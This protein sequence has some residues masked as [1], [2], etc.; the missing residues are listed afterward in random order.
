MGDAMH[1]GGEAVGIS[2]ISVLSSE[3]CCEPKT[4]LKN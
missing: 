1:M 4:T 3:F 2:E